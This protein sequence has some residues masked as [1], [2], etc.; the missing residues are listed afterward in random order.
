MP[1]IAP[2]DTPFFEL[3]A[4]TAALLHTVYGKRR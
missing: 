1:R 4:K 2:P 3:C